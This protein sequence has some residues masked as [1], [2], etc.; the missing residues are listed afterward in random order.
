MGAGGTRDG[1]LGEGGG[2][3]DLATMLTCDDGTGASGA[4]LH[5]I[6][7]HCSLPSLTFR[8]VK[9]G[10]FRHVWP[11]EAERYCPF[12]HLVQAADPSAEK[13]SQSQFEQVLLAVAKSGFCTDM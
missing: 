11:R 7:Q 8:D 1:G 2:G 3:G 9:A 5:E 6:K 4:S 12:G 10:H 13:E